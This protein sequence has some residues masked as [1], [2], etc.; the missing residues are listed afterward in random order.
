MFHTT[1]SC[2]PAGR[3]KGKL[4]VSYRPMPEAL[5]PQAT[6]I[7]ATYLLLHGAPVHIGDPASLGI[8]DL[9]RPDWGEPV[10][11]L[12]GDVPMFWACGVTPQVVALESGIDFMIAHAPGH[13][14]VADL[15]IAALAGCI[16]VEVEHE[17]R[18]S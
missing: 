16:T 5:V 1:Q 13:M 9:Q 10:E 6:R 7:S 4:V 18:T 12:S 11:A 14:F 3:F 8:D 2:R 15:A 17:R